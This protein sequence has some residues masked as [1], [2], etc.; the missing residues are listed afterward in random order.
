MHVL[1][2]LVTNSIS[3]CF[4]VGWA[5]MC[6]CDLYGR[7]LPRW[8]LSSGQQQPARKTSTIQV[9]NTHA[10]PSDNEAA[11]DRIG[12]QSDQNMHASLTRVE[13]TA[14]S[15][16]VSPSNG[17]Q[18]FADISQGKRSRNEPTEIY[19]LKLEAPIYCLAFT[20]DG[21]KLIQG[22]D[23]RVV[24]WDMSTGTISKSIDVPGGQT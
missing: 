3:S 14:K 6:I 21:K 11:A 24:I 18:P 16:P 13:P 4:I 12:D 7:C 1:I 9:A 15:A 5:R 2:R 23:G 17:V 10:G 20:P 22:S 8:F 19:S